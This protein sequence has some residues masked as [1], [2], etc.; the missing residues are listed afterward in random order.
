MTKST[1]ENIIRHNRTG[2]AA[3]QIFSEHEKELLSLRRLLRDIQHQRVTGGWKIEDY[4]LQENEP[5]LLKV[6][7][8]TKDL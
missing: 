1:L 2:F 6:V 8:Q 5:L 7:E 3:H 4:L